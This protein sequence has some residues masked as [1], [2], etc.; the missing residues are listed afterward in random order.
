MCPKCREPLLVME[1]DGVEVDHCLLCKGTWLDSGE[2]EMIA[3]RSGVDAGGLTKAI[4]SGRAGERT[5][6]RCPRCRR[7]LRV[8]SLGPPA[9]I[10]LDTCV[11]G[12]GLWFDQ[13]EMV[14][15]ISAVSDGEAGAISRF[16]A[17][18]YRSELESQTQGD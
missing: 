16:F 4:Q 3:E 12:H 6:R 10:E 7:R 13:G 11:R 1:L 5:D 18:L 17:D 9:S 15:L 2:I 8:I 14:V